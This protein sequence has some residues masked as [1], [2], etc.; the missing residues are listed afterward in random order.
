MILKNPNYHA[1]QAQDQDPH[2]HTQQLGKGR[3]TRTILY[4]SPEKIYN[5]LLIKINNYM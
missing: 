1:A 4:P 3:R 5:Q 2:L